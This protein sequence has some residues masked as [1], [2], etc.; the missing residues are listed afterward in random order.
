M[1]AVSG[2]M[3]YFPAIWYVRFLN[4][5]YRVPAMNWMLC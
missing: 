5:R 4:L 3:L 1:Y 2:L